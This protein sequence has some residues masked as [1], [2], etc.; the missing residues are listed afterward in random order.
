MKMKRILLSLLFFAAVALLAG[1]AAAQRG[2]RETNIWRKS[3][4]ATIRAGNY[5]KTCGHKM[6]NRV[7]EL[8]LRNNRFWKN[9]AKTAGICPK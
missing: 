4:G 9:C 8:Y 5:C 6:K 1:D 7:K 2:R 3:R